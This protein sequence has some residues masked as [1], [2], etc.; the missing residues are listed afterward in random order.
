MR[1]S[2]S[3]RVLS[4]LIDAIPL[5]LVVLGLHNLFIGGIIE[6]QIPNYTEHREVYYDNYAILSNNLEELSQD[7]EN[8]LITKE[9]YDEER[10]A[11]TTLFYETY[12]DEYASLVVHMIL[13]FVYSSIMFMVLYYVYMLIMKG[14]TFGRYLMG[15][16][17]RGKVNWFTLF[18]REVLWKHF[19]WIMFIMFISFVSSMIY[20]PFFLLGIFVVLGISIDMILISFTQ[21]KKTLRDTF[22]NTEVVYKGVNYPF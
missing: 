7:H 5:L 10:T 9:Y 20:V 11:I 3:K 15:A 16:E 22:S 21:Q 2:L 8:G 6:D 4:Y 17:L 14:N 12:E 19:F 1:V 18:M 13:T